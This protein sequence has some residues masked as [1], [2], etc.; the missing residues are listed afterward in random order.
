MHTD[1]KLFH[2]TLKKSISDCLDYIAQLLSSLTYYTQFCT[3]VLSYNDQQN[4]TDGSSL[5]IKLHR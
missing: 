3:F 5:K 4:S 2:S 1:Y